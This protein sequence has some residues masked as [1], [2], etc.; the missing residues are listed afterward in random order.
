[1]LLYLVPSGSLAHGNLCAEDRGL[2]FVH[3]GVDKAMR[4]RILLSYHYY[5]N[6]DLDGLF[7]TYFSEPYPD[8]FA[9]SGGFSAMTQGVD[10]DLDD[11]A[12]WLQRWGHLF[13][14]YANLDVIGDA[15]ATLLNQQRL[16]DKGLSPLPVFHT[17]EDWQYLERYIEQYP[18]VAL[19]GMVPYMRFP[20]KIMP[21]I[22]RAFRL[23]REGDNV[24]TVF[25]G[26]GATAWKVIRDLPWYSVDSSSWG[27]GFRYG[28]V[29]LFEAARGRFVNLSLGD[30]RSCYQY[31]PLI[32]EM[33]FDPADFADRARNDRAKIC[34]ISAL[35]YMRAEQWLRER[36]GEIHIPGRSAP[37]GLRAHLVASASSPGARRGGNMSV[38]ALAQAGLRV[39]LVEQSGD[40]SRAL[41]VLND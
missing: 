35:S 8:V 9:D 30:H 23:A 37:V 32:R 16:E 33:G 22:I 17:G 39:Y 36:H 1:M 28:R 40:T 12:G 4:L 3:H 5:R 27:T 26:F 34:A 13:N 14:T 25:H 21:W 29:P 6:T 41:E 10:I 15:E 24:R 19:G 2:I 31:A 11:Y 20:N 18:Y 7:A 38:T